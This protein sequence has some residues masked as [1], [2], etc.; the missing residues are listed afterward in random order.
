MIKNAG[1]KETILKVNRSGKYFLWYQ[2]PFPARPL[3]LYVVANC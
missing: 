3:R 1:E 2:D